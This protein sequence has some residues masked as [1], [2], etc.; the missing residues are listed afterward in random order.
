MR[1]ATARLLAGFTIALTAACG[2]ESLSL[3]DGTPSTLAVR[4][5]VDRDGDGG[6]TSA[7]D[8]PIASAEITAMQGE[9]AAATATSDAEGLASFTALVP[10]SYTLDLAA[11]PP[12]G[13]VLA[14]ASAPVVVAPYQGDALAAEFRFAFKPGGLTGAVYRDDNGSG[15]YEPGADTPAPGVS[16]ALVDVGAGAAPAALVAAADTVAEA[17][18]DADGAF[19]F[20]G[21]RPGDYTMEIG[22]VEGLTFVGGTSQAVTVGAETATTFD[23]EFEGDLLITIA[24]SRAIPDG[25][26][27]TIEGVITWQAQWR[28]NLDAFVQDGTAGITLFDFDCDFDDPAANCPEVTTGDSVRITG[29]RGSFNSE[30]QVSSLAS[31]E[32]LGS[33]G[34]PTPRAVSAAQIDAGEFQ[35]ELV[36]IDGTVTDVTVTNSFGTHVVTLTDAAGG[37]FSTYVDNRTGVDTTAWVVGGEYVL[38]GVLGFDDRNTPAA[39]LEIRGPNDL[40]SG[41]A[42]TPIVTARTLTGDTVIVEGVVTWQEQWSGG[43]VYFLQD[44]S[45]GISTFHSGAPTLQRGDVIRVQ[46]EVGAFRGEVQL[47]PV[48]TATVVG[49]TTVPTPRAVTGAEINAG[50]FQ[51]ELATI[52]GTV[53]SVLVLNSFDTHL[54]WLTDGAGTE[55]TAYADN[56]TGIASTDWAVGT[57]MVVRGVLGT[58]D[59][60]SPA[61]RIEPRDPNDMIAGPAPSTILDARAQAAGTSVTVEGVVTWQQ[62][63]DARVYYFQ[64]ATGGVSTFDSA[65]PALQRGDRIRITGDV[66]AFRSEVQ[67]S[68]VTALTVLGQ[69]AVPAPRAVTG[70][71]INAG[72]YQGELVTASGTVDSLQVFSFDN[73]LVWLTDGESTVFTAYIDSRNGVASADWTTGVSVTLTGILAIDDRNT[74]AARLEPRD[75]SDIQ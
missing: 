27:V 58:D 62:Q 13:A 7:S 26:P 71:E 15:A 55:F 53:D 72:Q 5:Y 25:R 60:N 48:L 30:L 44:G 43:P 8:V 29:V 54:T 34:E 9:A 20:E 61:A 49:Q 1:R 16:L 18:T 63:W 68:P 10:G 21:I 17:V 47:S 41:S 38:T 22:A 52:E 56:R 40:T 42:A 73:H 45:G 33:P 14:S 3:S 28:R 19:A 67:L 51:G 74:P 50:Q 65:E 35:A 69:E 24:E 6:F 75:P 23:I 70:A 37:S 2:E 39:R 36:T 32:L 66:G 46:G 4:V 31:I 11:T 12:T 64:D 57:T 59:R